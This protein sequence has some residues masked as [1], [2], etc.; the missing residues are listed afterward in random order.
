MDF[1]VNS[2]KIGI[3]LTLLLCAALP[4][5]LAKESAS[6]DRPSLAEILKAYGKETT[7][8]EFRE[9]VHRCGLKLYFR[10]Q[11][12]HSAGR[13]NRRETAEQFGGKGLVFA[14]TETKFGG[15]GDLGDS[16]APD[17]LKITGIRILIGECKEA[18]RFGLWDGELPDIEICRTPSALI[19]RY[20]NFDSDDQDVRYIGPN[21]TSTRRIN[22]YIPQLENKFPYAFVFI[23]GILAYIEIAPRTPP[24]N[25]IR[26]QLPP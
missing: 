5:G 23:D 15:S 20:P 24:P 16:D 21:R 12:V 14:A 10:K 22:Y 25:V 19:A 2:T 6:I 9:L 1:I 11:E 13:R 7:S 18:E 26:P 4:F 8:P 3:T 17:K